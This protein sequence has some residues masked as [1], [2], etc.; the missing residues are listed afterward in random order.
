MRFLAVINRPSHVSSQPTSSSPIP[1]AV[2]SSRTR[3]REDTGT[4]CF[5]VLRFTA[6]HRCCIF[7]K[8]KTRHS[9]SNKIMTPCIAILASL[10]GSGPKPT[11]SPRC[12]CI[13]IIN[14]IV[15]EVVITK[16]NY[17]SGKPSRDLNKLLA[18]SLRRDPGQEGLIR[19]EE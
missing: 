15:T 3:R 18:L 2:R 14:C 12:A 7:Y 8:L 17:E 11:K 4:P 16:L 13:E 1:C 10:Q 6:L 9:T 19:F 5:T